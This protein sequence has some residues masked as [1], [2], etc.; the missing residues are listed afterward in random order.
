MGT[1]D[2][3]M[4]ASPRAARAGDAH[5]ALAYAFVAVEREPRAFEPLFL[6]AAALHKVGRTAEAIP[7]YERAIDIDDSLPEPHHN[8]GCALLAEGRTAEAVERLVRALDLRPTDAAAFDALGLASLELGRPADA[9]ACF[10]A[11]LTFDPAS[12]ELFDGLGVACEG[13]DRIDEAIAAYRAALEHDPGNANAA[14]NLG[15]ALLSTGDVVEAL[16]WLD[17]AI[18]LQPRNG[19]FYLPLV[20]GGTL[21]VKPQHAAAMLELGDEIDHLPRA[22]RTELHFALGNLC[23]RDGRFDDAFRHLAAGNALKRAELSYDEAAALAHVQSRPD[24]LPDSAPAEVRR[25]AQGS[26]RPIFI[27][28]M[29]RS[30]STLLEQLLAAHPDVAAAGE[31]GILGPLARQGWSLLAERYLHATDALAA[32]KLRLTD[33]TLENTQLL[34]LIHATF[35]NARILH[36]RR[37]DLDGCFSCFATL[38]DGPRL[39]FAYDLGELGR[40]HRAYLAT[41]ERWRPSVA[42]QRMLEVSYERLVGA[43]ERE[44][45]RIIAFCGLRWDPACLA[46]HEARRTV[47][48]IGRAQPF[49]EHLAPLIEALNGAPELI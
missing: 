36:I 4:A 17:R 11:G 5:Q 42:P 33:K 14:C 3:A 28:G 21:P 49:L 32:G 18:E 38:F 22:Q 10:R 13:L 15:K 31:C 30:G 34:P 8:L 9:E 23:E 20:I 7:Y 25:S 45:R 12:S 27:V 2:D 41:M 48:S 46:F 39:P 44:A 43:F 19:R 29:P 24:A 16:R 26:E 40:Y 6:L 37:D 1:A 47:R 35:P